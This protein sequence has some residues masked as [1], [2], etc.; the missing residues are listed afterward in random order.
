MAVT[1]ASVSGSVGLAP[2]SSERSRR[3]PASATSSPD[4]TCPSQHQRLSEDERPRPQRCRAKRVADGKLARALPDHERQHGVEA[5]TRQHQCSHA[6]NTPASTALSRGS[7]SSPAT[8][9]WSGAAEVTTTSVSVLR[10]TRRM[11]GVAVD[12]SPIIRTATVVI[13]VLTSPSWRYGRYTVG[14][15]SRRAR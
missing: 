6:P 11:D 2:N 12:G 8:N 3:A 15:G 4:R 13:I 10:T 1:V 7:A 14:A 5:E 9:A